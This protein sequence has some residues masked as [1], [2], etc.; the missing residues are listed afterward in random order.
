MLRKDTTYAWSTH[1]A[2]VSDANKDIDHTD[3]EIEWLTAMFLGET[4]QPS[5]KPVR[6][7]FGQ[8]QFKIPHEPIKEPSK[9]RTGKRGRAMHPRG[10]YAPN[11]VGVTPPSTAI[12]LD[13]V[14]RLIKLPTPRSERVQ[15]KGNK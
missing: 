14:V 4:G 11:G 12:E 5:G 9:G 10:G 13:K 7:P 8:V 3:L 15:L 2:A 6:V 1:K